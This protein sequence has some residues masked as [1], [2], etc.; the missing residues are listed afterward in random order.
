MMKTLKVLERLRNEVDSTGKRSPDEDSKYDA[1]FN[2]AY[3]DMYALRDLH[4]L[5]VQLRATIEIEGA[6]HPDSGVR[7]MHLDDLA[8]ELENK[9]VRIAYPEQSA[10]EIEETKSDEQIKPHWIPPRCT[11]FASLCK[12]CKYY[13]CQFC[14]SCVMLLSPPTP[15]GASCLCLDRA[16][17]DELLAHRCKHYSTSDEN[18]QQES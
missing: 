10:V 8:K 9:I 17:E 15:E 16:T 18:E 7:F 14:E 4:T 5:A 12:L 1:I 2:A 13:D 11:A 3:D 6:R